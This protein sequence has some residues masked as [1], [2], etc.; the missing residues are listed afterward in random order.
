MK[1]HIVKPAK[2]S[3]S[4]VIE[5]GPHP[6]TGKR[7]QKWITLEGDKSAAE[8]ELHKQ[9]N[10]VKTGDFI[11]PDK[12]T[13]AEFF[14]QW[15]SVVAEQK[16]GHKTFERYESIVKNHIVPALGRLP[17]PKL[18]A[19]HIE[20]HY[21]RLAKEGRKD[22]REGGLSA[23]TILHHHRL[24]SEAMQKA[25]TW[26]LRTHNPADGVT[27][28]GIRRL[29]VTPIDEA[30]AAWLV[31]AA[32]GTRLYIPVLI[33]VCA[34]LRRGEILAVRW[35]DVDWD[36]E[37]FNIRRALEE[38]KRGIE[39]KEPKSK[40]GRRPVAI[41]SI[42]LEVLQIHKAKQQE[43]REALGDGYQDNDLICCVEEGSI[44]K[45]SAFTS[46]YRDLLRR[47]KLTGP[48]F[49]ALRHAHASHLLKDGVD[50]KVISRR[51]GHSRA[52][53]T[54]DV[55]AHLMPGQDEEAAKRTDAGLRK[56]LKETSRVVGY[57]GSSLGKSVSKPVAKWQKQA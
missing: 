4:L 3:Y 13:V 20:T 50:I 42:L 12:V 45:P 32:E 41:P 47:R 17:L 52:S 7:Q 40:S 14:D 25:V 33:A 36:L 21:A 1:G 2:G 35:T 24:I 22:G 19:L 54:M 43:Y 5:L 23:Q 48:N 44:W 30:Q 6:E 55:Y 8:D 31:T 26:K 18:T 51:L 11:D 39:F 53:F 29:E 28:P 49:H 10:L 34:G 27:T 9:I 16:V 15:L 57:S 38:S 56:A 46:A 37:A